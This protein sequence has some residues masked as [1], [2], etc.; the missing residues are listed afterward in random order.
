M[1][2][3]ITY[4]CVSPGQYTVFFTMYRD[5][6]GIA[7]E[8]SISINYRSQQCG[9]NSNITLSRVPSTPQAPNPEDVTP[10][11]PGQPSACGGNGQFGVQ[12]VVY[13][14]TLNLPAGCGNDWILSWDLCCRNAAINTLSNPSNQGT[15]I[16]ARLNNQIA[17]CNNSPVFLN[18]PT[19]YY[20]VNSNVVYNHGVVDPD[21]D[22]LVFSLVTPF[23]TQGQPVTYA[24]GFSA[25]N[26]ITT[27]S[28]FNLDPST[29][30]I[31]FTPTQ[32]QVGVTAVLVQEYRNG[33]LVGSVVRDM[34]FI[35]Q[36]CNNALPTATG[37]NGTNN[38]RDTICAGAQV[39]FTINSADA[40]TADVVTMTWNNA[41]VGASFTTNGAPRP[42]G[43]FTWTPPQSIQPGNYSFTVKVEDNACPL[44]GSNIYSYTIVVQPNPNPPVD[45]GS[46]VTICQGAS[47]TLTATT[48]AANGVGYTWTDGQNTFQGQTIAVSPV[49][50]TVYTVTLEYADGCSS[51]DN[52]VVTVNAKPVV[53]VFPASATICSGGSVLLTASSPSAN[54]F[55]WSPAGGLS[56]TNCAST[57]ASPSTTTTY[58]VVATDPS[59]CQSDPTPVTVTA[60]TPPPTASCE[61]IHVT[62]TGTGDGSQLSPTNLG[63]ALNKARCNNS[64]LKLAVGTY[65]IDTAIT[66]ITSYTTIEGGYDPTTWTKSSQPGITEIFRGTNNIEGLPSAPRLVA[67]YLNSASYVRFQDITIRTADAPLS[68]GFGVSTY[69]VHLTN[70]SNYDFVRT[71]IIAG[72]AGAGANGTNG[73]NGTNGGAGGNASCRNGGSGGSGAG[74]NNGGNGGNGGTADFFGGGNNGSAGQTAPNG[75][76]AGGAGGARQGALCSGNDGSPGG[77]GAPGVSGTNGANGLPFAFVNGFFV[78]GTQGANGTNGTNGRGGGGGG[79]AGGNTFSPGLGGGAGGG[80]GGGGTGGSGGF[81]GGSSFGIYAYLNGSAGNATQSNITAGNPGAGGVGGSG[82]VGGTGGS[83]GVGGSDGGFPIGGCGFFNFCDN[84]NGDGGNGG[85]GGSG[86]SGGTALGGISRRVYIDGGQPLASNDTVFNLAAQQV[87]NVSNTSC[88]NTQVTFN[89]SQGVQGAWSFGADANPQTGNASPSNTEYTTIGRKDITFNNDSY[90]GFVNIAIDQAS[91]VPEIL[92]SATPFGVDSYFVCVGQSASFQAQINGATSYDWDFGGAISPS[93]YTGPQYQTFTNLVFNTPGEYEVKLRIF[94]DCCGF[95]PFKTVFLRVVPQPNVT[96]TG[97]NVVCSGQDITLVAS[98]AETYVWSPAFGLSSTTDSI[99]VAAPTSPVTYTVIGASANGQCTSRDSIQ[100]SVG[101]TPDITLTSTVA[102]C[103]DN[104]SISSTVL[105]Q[106]GSYSY[107]WDNGATTANLPAVLA[108]TYTVTVTDIASGCTATESVFVSPGNGLIAFVDSSKGPSC[109][110]ACDGFARVRPINGVGPFTYAWSTSATT[111]LITGLCAGVY[112]VTV[113][114]ADQCFSVATVTIVQSDTFYAEIRTQGN[115]LCVDDRNGYA[116]ANGVGGAGP[117]VYNWSTSPAQDSSWAINLGNGT[118]TVT[119]SDRNGCEATT[120][121]TITSPDTLKLNAV[122]TNISC[123]GANDGRIVLFPSGGTRPYVIRWS[124]NPQ[125]ADTTV[126]SL[127]PGN[128]TV[129]ITDANNCSA[130]ETF[131]ITDPAVLTLNPVASNVRCNVPNSGFIA[132]NPTGGTAPFTYQ[133]S[134]TVTQSGDSAVNLGPGTYFFTVTDANGCF[135]TGNR[136]ISEPP[137]ITVGPLSGT[138]NIC[139]GQ[140]DGTIVFSGTGGT[141]PLNFIVESG[142]NVFTN[143]NGTFLGLPAGNYTARITD[144]GGCDIEVGTYNVVEA[145]RDVFEFEVDSTSCFGDFADGRITIVA[146]DTPNAPY[147]YAINNEP[148]ANTMVFEGLNNGVYGIK[149]INKNQC[150]DSVTLEVFQPLQ[151][152]ASI[153]PQ[154]DTIYLNL[155]ESAE[156]EAVAVNAADPVYE[157]T[158]AEGVSCENCAITSVSPRVHTTYQVRVRNAGGNEECFADATRF[159]YVAIK[160]VLPNVFTPNGDGKND[161]FYP[162]SNYEPEVTDFRIYNRWG[163][164]A[165]NSAEPWDGSFEGKPQPAGT[166]TYFIVYYEEDAAQPGEK[167]ER[168][169]TGALTL[170]R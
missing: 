108:G 93:T 92:T 25:T 26:P 60:N 161:R 53:V 33:E 134:P 106:N 28:G 3:N 21:G 149:V 44:K 163:Q 32:T 125:L 107:L 35:I 30:D 124:Q 40:N 144:A 130:V 39:S 23:N 146:V 164:L 109:F 151:I 88:T 50:T 59:G 121:V 99:V 119:V 129:T 70:C 34:Q 140:N 36:N 56:C 65:A 57:T 38:F 58:N 82:G 167:I 159:V 115:N 89:H 143:N 150:I 135:A 67:I 95:S 113:T 157:W 153:N 118:Y 13:R 80:G 79:G 160:T 97:P 168:R 78:P 142:S 123:N 132:T 14:G 131:T 4:Q 147:Q 46:N 170:L 116:W 162:I 127:V 62:T 77:N 169:K 145:A 156:L 52:V 103:G 11:C 101:A 6:R 45:A 112:T 31:T 100:V 104:G 42:T 74:G 165:H 128:Y 152:Q 117:F 8:N 111:Q 154:V 71:Q 72:N 51:S 73:V 37:I 138:P 114:A 54:V 96:I 122:V 85:S 141:P 68:S 90:T 166:Y 19:A 24:A 75:G 94:S 41:I 48:Q 18:N 158:P 83:G 9:I 15:Y 76:G 7:A 20:C 110:A 66:N 61:V 120:Q 22:S 1:G 49:S 133:W 64:W 12:K 43:T 69:G 10:V 91:Y 84:N 136:A 47:T 86:G 55:N 87:I 29:G 105:P 16:E 27:A 139:F 2:A 102:D 63:D 81:G 17:Q 155:G 137:S 148:F 98:G 5:C 126:G